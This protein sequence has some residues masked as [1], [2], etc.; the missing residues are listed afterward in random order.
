MNFIDVT[1]TL[2]LPYIS[3]TSTSSGISHANWHG[4]WTGPVNWAS[5]YVPMA[6]K[7]AGKDHATR[8][9]FLDLIVALLNPCP[10][11]VAHG[12]ISVLY[13]YPKP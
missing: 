12:G 3:S 4:Y 13:S 2:E 7:Q 6:Y 9:F 8:P 11:S 5:I 10:S 1:G